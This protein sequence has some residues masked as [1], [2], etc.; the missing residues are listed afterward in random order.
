MKTNL[1]LLIYNLSK[2]YMKQYYQSK[3]MKILLNN[4]K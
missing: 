3:K 2:N 4:K 1:N